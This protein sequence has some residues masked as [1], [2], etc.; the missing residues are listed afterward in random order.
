VSAADAAALGLTSAPAPA[1]A[2][3]SP[4]VGLAIG[5]TGAK[6][7][8]LQK[9]LIA[10]GVPVHGGADGAFGPATK[11]ALVAYQR[12]N[13]LTA[14]GKV[15]AAT[16][17]RLGLGTAAAGGSPSTPSGAAGYVGL[18]VG[19]RGAKVKEL[20]QALL[21]TGL[22]VRGGADGVF[23]PATK[24]ALIAFQSVNGIPQTGVLTAAGARILGLG[25]PSGPSGIVG[26]NGYPR[27]GEHSTR[28]AA[29]Q[30]A[31]MSAGIPVPGGADG[32]FGS[33]TAGAVM[34][35]QRRVGL[36][37]TGKVDE[38]TAG[39]LGL[40]AAPAPAP[41]ST[42]G[43]EFDVFPVQ[44]RCYFGDTW[45]APRGGGRT[46]L[47]VDII[48]A[49]GNLLYAVVDGTI[50]KR[51]F[52]QR[53]SRAGNGLRLQQANGTYFTYLH[54]LDVAPGI[55]VGKKVRAGDVIGFVGSTGNSATPH[56]HLE[57]HPN[58]GAA[59]NPYP[60]AKA[61]DACHVTAPR[62]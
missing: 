9:A 53:G 13:G 12:W 31:L 61:A 34:A 47:G 51:Y 46:H 29:L 56:L 26:V 5:A 3:K 36:G 16:A 17:A 45:Q 8:T 10:A 25:S 6:V 15:D 40:G 14:S 54:L 35:F 24:A 42:A 1:P 7:T 30:R 33:S 21:E 57:I 19:S 60:I 58:G 4:Y 11:A 27:F 18:R 41:I 48:A 52:D 55:K 43:I 50:S 32:M 37:V 20:Q 49:E 44:G 62:R 2:A 28:V 23:G 59:V 38:R 39:R 22:T